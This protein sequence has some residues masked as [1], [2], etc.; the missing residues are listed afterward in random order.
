MWDSVQVLLA[1]MVVVVVVLLFLYI[2]AI[3]SNFIVHYMM[4]VLGHLSRRVCWN[5]P[6]VLRNGWLVISE[7]QGDSS[8]ESFLRLLTKVTVLSFLGFFGVLEV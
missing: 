1:V 8:C 2:R 3:L 4:M 5:H 6:S 7:W